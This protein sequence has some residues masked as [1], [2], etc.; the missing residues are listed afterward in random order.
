VANVQKVSRKDGRTAY[1]IDYRSPDGGRVRKTFDKKVDAQ[2]YLGKVLA[3][4]RE[5]QYEEIFGIPAKAITF[6]ELAGHYVENYRGQKCFETFKRAHVM[7]LLDVFGRRP[8]SKITYLDLEKLRNNRKLTPTWKGTVRADAS[9]NREMAVLKH[10]LNKAVE[11][12][13]LEVNPFRKGSSLMLKENNKRMRFLS[14]GEVAALL[15]ES[16][17]HLRPIVQ[18]ALLTGMRSGEILTLTWDQVRDGIIYL[19]ETKSNKGRQIPVNGSLEIILK[20]LRRRYQLRSSY[21]FCK[22]DGSRYG[23]VKTAFGSACRRAGITGFRFHDLRHTFAS[24]MVMAGVDMKTLQ[25]ILGHADI[26]MT[27]RYA[28]LSPGHLRE[29]VQAV[30]HLVRTDG[31]LLDTLSP[32]RNVANTKQLI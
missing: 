32:Q 27:M 15:R 2:A 10:M 12:G 16:P 29:A 4:K 22:E 31:H 17:D 19:T 14:E 7:T 5:G 26:K 24:H 9:V 3:A 25:E 1:R 20:E 11:W 8:L 30:N 13:M 6:E 18:T 23:S 28:H 21:V